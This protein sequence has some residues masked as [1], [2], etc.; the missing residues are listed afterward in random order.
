MPRSESSVPV[1]ERVRDHRAR[2][3]AQGLRPIQIWVPDVRSP[4]F[5][6]Q[7][8]AQSLGARLAANAVPLDKISMTKALIFNDYLDASMAL[9]FL[10]LVGIILVC[11]FRSWITPG[12]AVSIPASE[13]ERPA[14]PEENGPLRCC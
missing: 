7:A 8:H 5:V 14:I 10:S 13:S 12:R 4:A 9:V 6:A 1:V 3:R 11:A 2:L